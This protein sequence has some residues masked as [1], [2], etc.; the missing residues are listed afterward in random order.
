M[1]APTRSL[2]ALSLV[3]FVL[4]ACAEPAGAP[5]RA[6]P[7]AVEAPRLLD[8]AVVLAVDELRGVPRLLRATRPLGAPA[9]VSAEAAA[10]LHVARFRDAFGVTAPDL[11]AASPLYVSDTGRGAVLVALRQR[12]SGVEV[13]GADLKVL[14]RDDLELVAISGSPL[15]LPR[16]ADAPAF[17][18]TTTEALAA[19]VEQ[20]LGGWQDKGRV[21][22]AGLDEAGWSRLDVTGAVTVRD[23]RAQLTPPT[24][25]KAVWF[26]RG[27]ALVPAFL[28]EVFVSPEASATSEAWRFVVAATD[29]ELLER[30]DLWARGFDY[31]VFADAS[32]L[33]PLD[34]PVADHTPHPTGLP[35]GSLPPFVAPALVAVEGLN[36]NPSGG[37]DPWLEASALQTFGNNVDAYADFNAPDGYSNGDLRAVPSAFGTFDRVYDVTRGAAA[38]EAQIMA[39]V[40]HLFY[41]TNWLHDWYYDS[42]FDEAAG[43]AQRSNYGRGGAGFDPLLAQSL[44]GLSVGARNDAVTV[45][46]GDGASPRL[47][48]FAWSGRSQSSLL[49]TPP[50]S[51]VETGTATFGPSSFDMTG[52]LALADDGVGSASDGCEPLINDVAGRVVLVDAGGC[53][54]SF[55]A[56]RAQ[57]AGAIAIVVVHDAPGSPPL[58]ED[59]NPG[60]FIPA[61]SI[62]LD[63]GTALKAALQQGPV[64]A[65]LQR[66]AEPLADGALDSLLI[67]HEWTHVLVR[68]LSDCALKQCFA[69][70]EGF[71][72]FVALHLALREGDDLGGTFA[73]PAYAPR[74][75]GDVGYFG[76]RRVPYSVDFTRNA[77]T[78]RHL[79]DGEPLPATHPINPDAMAGA[80]NSEIHNAGEVWATMLLEGYVALLE[81]GSTSG[82]SFDEVRRAMSDYVVTGLKLMPVDATLT[83][84]RDALLAAALAQRPAD[85]G[86][87]AAAFARRGAGTCAVSPA[88]DSLDFSGV[89]ES[90]EVIPRIELG[91][92]HLDD[93]RRSCDGDGALD[94]GE[95]GVLT[96]SLLNASPSA[97]SAFELQVSSTSASL[98]FPEGTVVSVPA[99]PAFSSAE[100]T[101]AVD[102]AE[103]AASLIGLDLSVAAAGVPGCGGSAPQRSF[104][105]PASFDDELELSRR[106]AFESERS[107]W[108]LD[109][110]GAASLWS[111]EEVGP[112]EHAWRGEDAPYHSDT[113]LVSPPLV[114]DDAAALVLSFRHRHTFEASEGQFWDGAVVEISDDDGATWTDV[115]TWADPGYGGT[116]VAFAGNPLAARPAFVGQNPSW[117][118]LDDVTVD[119][120][121]AFAGDTVR[122]RFRVGTDAYAGA[123][124]WEIDDVELQ[125]ITNTPFS[126]RID[127][128]ASCP[129]PS[130]GGPGA[131]GDAGGAVDAGD[132]D[133]GDPDAGSD[134]AGGDDAG[135]TDAGDTDGGDPDGGDPDAGAPDGGNPHGGVT[136]AGH[137]DAGDAPDDGDKDAPSGCSC[138]A[139]DR[140][141]SAPWPGGVAAAAL[142]IAGRRRR[143]ARGAAAQR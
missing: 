116:L 6:A 99:M 129:A 142:L 56:L 130:D 82:R 35:D 38:D 122:V 19:A 73:S 110:D 120:G 12:L 119:L 59:G 9:G 109:G 94:D 125:G 53:T 64:T 87:L 131:G 133:A 20:G 79:A 88:R 111:R 75:F 77:L 63:D 134:D 104:V 76:L 114:V 65:A 42:G 84:A 112:L 24:R 93:S 29:G 48:M 25:A 45:V 115:S 113:A 16:P 86:L 23:G 97:S 70:E 118:E 103:D 28:V 83:E 95:R 78:F 41:V 141:T 105:I 89:I 136:D 71:A 102:L 123:H 108:T 92:A 36:T 54:F 26:P 140:T 62:T 107:T 2:L 46:P 135:D 85:A 3:S 44:S 32:D 126:A 96:L 11:D 117:P 51:S 37:A 98:G 55:K 39:G 80:L 10:R 1:N 143:R 61:L 139:S 90:F 121:T 31:R 101:L 15:P 69:L 43:N 74:A 52:P 14:M 22:E 106:D 8:G 40:T 7:R 137:R 13:H 33:R 34:G 124:G 5:K 138:D 18:L 68:R 66:S 17:R 60:V 91:A 67:A 50:G 81:D 57:S 27:A 4:V 47:K 132:L 49:V 127:D 72:D 58:M 30:R 128:R 21:V 100:V